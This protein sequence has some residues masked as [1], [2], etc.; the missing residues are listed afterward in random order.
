MH[1]VVP[2]PLKGAPLRG[3]PQP[4]KFLF[5]LC[6]DMIF[7][8]IF[9]LEIEPKNKKIIIHVFLEIWIYCVKKAIFGKK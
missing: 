5:F 9:M 6:F 7:G 8:T 3:L 1:H 4:K 2:L